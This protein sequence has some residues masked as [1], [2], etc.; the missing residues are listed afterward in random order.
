MIYYIPVLS[1]N[2]VLV[3]ATDFYI[4]TNPFMVESSF[5]VSSLRFFTHMS[6]FISINNEIILC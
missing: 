6:L 5:S 3:M 2:C 1:S 4:L